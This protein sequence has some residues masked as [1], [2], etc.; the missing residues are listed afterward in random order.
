MRK[1]VFV[2]GALF[3]LVLLIVGCGQSSGGGSSSSN[4]T[5]PATV[6]FSGTAAASASD[7]SKMGVTSLAV[8]T[9]AMK[10]QRVRE[11]VAMGIDEGSVRAM[12]LK[13]L[14]AGD[15]TATLYK[16]GTDGTLTSVATGTVTD[17]TGAYSLSYTNYSTADAYVIRLEKASSSTGKTM[18]L[19]VMI[20]SSAAATSD[21]T[22]TL[23][24]IFSTPQ[25]TLLR[26]IIQSKVVDE[27]GGTNAI[28]KETLK[29]IE[30]LVISKI[31]TLVTVEGM[32]FSTVIDSTATENTSIKN[33]INQSFMDPFIK[34]A[35]QAI[36]FKAGIA[37]GATDLTTAK[38]IMKEV[39]TY[40]TGSP[41]G[42]PGDILDAF[43]AAYVSGE[44]K[45]IATMVP[46]MNQCTVP[47]ASIYTEDNVAAGLKALIDA[48]YQSAAAAGVSA[49][50]GPQIKI[51]NPVIQAAFPASVYFG[52]TAAELKAMTFNVPQI[53]LMLPVAEVIAAAQT[54]T[55]KFNGPQFAVKLGFLNSLAGVAGYKIMHAELKVEPWE[56][57]QSVDWSIPNARPNVYPV[58]TSFLDVGNLADPSATGA[59]ITARLTY[60]TTTDTVTSVSYTREVMIPQ[61]VSMKSL[62]IPKKSSFGQGMKAQE[63]GPPPGF[64]NFS[65]KPWNQGQWT[66][67]N[68]IP[69]NFQRGTTATIEVLENGTVIDTRMV[70]ITSVD[71][72]SAAISFKVPVDNMFDSTSPLVTTFLNTSKPVLSWSFGVGQSTINFD[73]LKKAY[74][75]EVREWN[76]QTNS[77]S[78]NG[79]PIWSSWS[80]HEFIPAVQGETAQLSLPQISTS[81]TY[82]IMGAVVGLD[83]DGWPVVSSS[84]RSTVFKVSSEVTV[85]TNVVTITGYVTMPAGNADPIKVGIFRMNQDMDFRNNSVAPTFGPTTVSSSIYSLPI[86]F[87]TLAATGYGG[88]DPIAWIDKDGD[89][90]IDDA[91]GEFPFFPVKHMEYHGGSL[92]A[93]DKDFKCI[94]PVTAT[95]N[96][97]EYNVD[98]TWGGPPTP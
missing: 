17:S 55:T 80:G 75:I 27:L 65:I 15:T 47:V 96:T 84:W 21:A 29:L 20:D 10:E 69:T 34:K 58:L 93:M 33:A 49:Q 82:A 73:S 28:D 54:Q 48:T 4:L 36:K 5:V 85:V 56:D 42:I 23:T 71:L 62:S 13:P 9:Q 98:M 11:L 59:G 74:A 88:Y 60:I 91:S 7:L 89:G 8:E 45:S 83:A 57:W 90:E 51:Q 31:N 76:T 6:T 53:I 41:K 18:Q 52:K 92:N 26:Q 16:V 68:P 78:F 2:L 43:A 39:F 79:N 32:T 86:S 63:M 64:L 35:I 22:G 46:V 67:Q 25:T 24:G 66:P 38:K 30:S 95:S 72:T 12:D 70:D 44:T 77:P 40:L 94:G 61:S 81:G 37:K 19:E 1:L 14:A 50:A 97:S 87:T 3:L